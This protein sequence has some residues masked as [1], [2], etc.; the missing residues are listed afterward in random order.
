MISPKDPWRNY[1]GMCVLYRILNNNARCYKLFFKAIKP[2]F[3][4]A[5]AVNVKAVLSQ[6]G[7]DAIYGADVGLFDDVQGGELPTL[8]QQI[9]NAP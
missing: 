8:R 4:S 3:A 2:L 5:L 7:N 1:L 9:E 6:F